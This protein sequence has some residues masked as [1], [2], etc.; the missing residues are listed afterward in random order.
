MAEYDVIVKGGMIVDGLRTPRY[1]S[2]IAIKDGK[3]AKIGGLGSGSATKVL[4]ASGLIVAPGFVDL[5]TH[6]DAQIQWDPYCTMSGWHGVTSVAIGN[7]G[8][9]F[10][11]V[12]PKDQE[13]SMLSLSRNEAIP[14]KTMQE[15]M[16]W[17]WETYPEF[18]DSIE[19]IPKGINVISYV[20]LTPVYGYVM[21]W[22]EAK[23]RRPTEAEL[24]EM[25]RLLNEG[26]DAGACGWSAQVTGAFSGQRD[27]DGTPMITD[28][29]TNEEI[30]NFAKVL[31]ERDEGSIELSYRE[32]GEEGKTI[33]D[34]TMNFF[35]EV[36]KAANR[37]ILYQ[38]VAANAQNPETYRMRLRWLE[39]CARRGLKV[40]GQGITTRDAMEM[41]FVDWNL[42]DQSPLWREVTLG[43]PEERKAKMADP[44][45][46]GKLRAEWDSGFRPGVTL[47]SV[48][49]LIVAEVGN[50][51]FARF[52]GMSIEQIAEQEGKH[53]VDAVL[54][55]AVADNLETEF[56][57]MNGRDN[58]EYAA[59]V[60]RSPHVIAGLSDG[61]AHVK[62]L[63]FGSYPTDML[64]WLVRE[65]QLL[66]L[67]EAHYKLSYLPAHLGGFKHRGFLRE[68][69]PA[70]IIVYDLENLKLLP[71][72][73]AV[74]Q[75]GGEWRRVQKAEGY[76]WTL[77]NGE[78]TFE[79][80]EAT[81]AL[82]G[83]LLRH[84][85]G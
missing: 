45:M 9:G 8:F 78:V 54:D 56:Q 16:L 10:A 70:D 75:P 33:E 24:K 22:E 28:L 47:G 51:E 50:P 26:L 37:P 2:D 68:D 5:H 23:K 57:A 49:G 39:D 12:G 21:G 46:R 19:R 15:G 61:G 20:P 41:T 82:P 29:M 30:L 32:T 27:Y 62:F 72:E 14:L 42:F 74:D 11:P 4:D 35:E 83:R 44:E 79:D 40:Y 85:R 3:I 80:G 77:V 60:L 64:I 36:A 52:E 1:K 67:E 55:L 73:V 65:E 53:I 25:N 81:G 71:A 17:D 66:T 63:T 38:A 7:C 18:L 76:R 59:E 84:G 6:Y 13:R 48:A 34:V 69:A 31:G 58:P 43:T